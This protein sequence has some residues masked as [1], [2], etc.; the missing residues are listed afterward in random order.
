[1]AAVTLVTVEMLRE[2]WVDAPYA[3]DR[4]DAL[5]RLPDAALQKALEDA[6]RVAEEDVYALLDRIRATATAALLEAP[7]P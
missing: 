4:L 6:H 1:M 5:L 3:R 7:R 2:D